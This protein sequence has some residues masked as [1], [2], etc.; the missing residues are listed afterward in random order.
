LSKVA[1]AGSPNEET[2]VRL[3]ACLR[4]VERRMPALCREAEGRTESEIREI[5]RA[6]LVP[7]VD[8]YFPEP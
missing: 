1:I 5:I 6:R 7:V 4:S 8:R 2:I 3:F